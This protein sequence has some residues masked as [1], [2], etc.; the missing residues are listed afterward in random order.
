MKPSK[1]NTHTYSE[2]EI[3]SIFT[4]LGILSPEERSSFHPNRWL[5]GDFQFYEENVEIRL[6]HNTNP[7]PQ[8]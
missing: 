1:S 2:K 6:S 7:V 5:E 3:E 8:S 4:D